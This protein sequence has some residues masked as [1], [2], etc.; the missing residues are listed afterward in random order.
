MEQDD[1]FTVPWPVMIPGV[2]CE[3][4]PEVHP[5]RGLWTF[6]GLT[7][8]VSPPTHWCYNKAPTISTMAKQN[9]FQNLSDGYS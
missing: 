8:A 2:Q 9:D 4:S 1:F 6:T 3:D 7:G 5:G